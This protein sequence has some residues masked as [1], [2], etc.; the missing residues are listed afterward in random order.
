MAIRPIW[1]RAL[2]WCTLLLLLVVNETVGKRLPARV[3]TVTQLSLLAAVCVATVYTAF[4]YAKTPRT[5]DGSNRRDAVR[6]IAESI[7]K[8]KSR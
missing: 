7:M 2:F 4:K 1:R 5:K 8:K 3:H 6:G